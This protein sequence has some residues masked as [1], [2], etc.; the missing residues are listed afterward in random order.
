MALSW[1]LTWAAAG[2]SLSA[3]LSR[4]K[5]RRVLEAISGIALLALA[6]KVAI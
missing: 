1:H 5:P 6:L 3:M 4:T 2:G